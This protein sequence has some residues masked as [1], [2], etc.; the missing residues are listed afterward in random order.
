MSV[1][2]VTVVACGALPGCAP[3]PS[4]GCTEK[5]CGGALACVAGR[6]QLNRAGVRPAIDNP[7]AVRMTL[8]AT[9][10]AYVHAG[11]DSGAV[12]LVYDLGRRDDDAELL[13]RFERPLGFYQALGTVVE[14]YLVLPRATEPAP[15]PSSSPRPELTSLAVV[16]IVDPWTPAAASW[17]ARPSLDS[18][19]RSTTTVPNVGGPAS[20]RLVRLD[21]RALV[22]GWRAHDTKDEG[23]AV[24]G[25]KESASGVSF[26]TP[27]DAD[28]ATLPGGGLPFLELYLAP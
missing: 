4:V 21:V 16:R 17:S 3:P 5:S 28:A 23:L 6:C 2:L 15:L 8:T 11:S 25:D 26:A 22:A 20:P 1:A 14:A 18:A 27:A 12:P 19:A 7:S 9:A 10:M 13:L 24:I